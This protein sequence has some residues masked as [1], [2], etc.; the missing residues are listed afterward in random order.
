MF[1]KTL[2]TTASVVVATCG[3][4]TAANAGNLKLRLIDVNVNTTPDPTLTQHID[5]DNNP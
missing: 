3:A 4:M 2:L 1:K 5:K